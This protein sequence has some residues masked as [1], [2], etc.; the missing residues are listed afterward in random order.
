MEP[1][2]RDLFAHSSS[3]RELDTTTLSYRFP[4]FPAEKQFESFQDIKDAIFAQAYA[5]DC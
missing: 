3:W 1:Q 4:I 2:L 5:F